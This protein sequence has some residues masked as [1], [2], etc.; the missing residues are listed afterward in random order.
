VWRA[1]EDPRRFAETSAPSLDELPGPS[2][3]FRFED[4]TFEVA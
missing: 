4:T 1:P 3:V 2:R